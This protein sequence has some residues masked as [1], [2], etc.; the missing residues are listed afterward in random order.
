MADEEWN[1]NHARAS[2]GQAELKKYEEK[3]ARHLAGEQPVP[4]A[5][6]PLPFHA[7]DG[8][9]HWDIPTRL[10]SIFFIIQYHI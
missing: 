1:I 5:P 3:Y 2:L 7:G 9:F 8:N 6:P 4:P 10:I